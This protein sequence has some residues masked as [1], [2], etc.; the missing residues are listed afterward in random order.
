MKHTPGEWHFDGM[1]YVWSGPMS[2]VADLG[3][4][5]DNEPYLARM[6]GV[7]RGATVE[8]QRAN[9]Y[10]MAASPTLREAADVALAC[11]TEVSQA[12]A[13]GDPRYLA[14]VNA[15]AQLGVAILKAG[16]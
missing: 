8:E 12:F 14:C 5:E 10:L 9:G 3:I 7:G 11:I 16:A 1:L 15:S 2:M 6:R 13:D 4:A